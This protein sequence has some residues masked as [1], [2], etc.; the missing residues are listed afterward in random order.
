MNAPSVDIMEMLDG[1]S[2]LG[3]TKGEDLF[4]TR[5]PDVPDDLVTLFDDGG[6]E[7]Q[8]N[9]RRNTSD[10]Y[11]PQVS[12]QVRNT[13]YQLGYAQALAVVQFLHATGSTV[14][15]N[16]LYVLIRAKSDPQLLHWDE[17]DR[18]VFVCNF[19]VQRRSNV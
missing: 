18:A 8:L 4:A 9:L 13:D 15:D 2:A 6:D 7:P 19:E 17:N 14:V 3:L 5:M 1:D 16:T 10:Y 12:M 11:R